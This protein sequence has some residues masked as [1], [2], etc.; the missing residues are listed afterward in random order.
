[1]ITV[2]I[3]E[4]NFT[5]TQKISMIDNFLHVIMITFKN[6]IYILNK[7]S[8]YYCKPM[9]FKIKHNSKTGPY[10]RGFEMGVQVYTISRGGGGGWR[11]YENCL[12]KFSQKGG[13]LDHCPRTGIKRGNNQLQPKISHQ[14]FTSKTLIVG[15]YSLFHGPCHGL[16]H[17]IF[18][19]QMKHL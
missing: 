19:H 18:T 9:L 14:W 8:C 15:T 6:I 16:H 11:I 13:S 17:V 12:T 2:N 3:N 1:M 7:S 4:Y 10:P 5:S